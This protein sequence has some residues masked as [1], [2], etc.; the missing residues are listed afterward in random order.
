M[1]RKAMKYNSERWKHKRKYI[2]KRD[3]YTDQVEARYG[4]TEEATI[5][6][7]IY[8]AKDYPEYEWDNDNLISV[9]VKTHNRLH[10]RNSDELSEEGIALMRRT[11]LRRKIND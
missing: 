1:K 5:V 9:S 7:H 4:R 2:L 6:H 3:K 11:K 8:P 10:I